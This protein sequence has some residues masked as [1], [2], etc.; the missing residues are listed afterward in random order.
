MIAIPSYSKGRPSTAT[1]DE[2]TFHIIFV[3]MKM[4][5]A[6]VRIE[7]MHVYVCTEWLVSFS[8]FLLASVLIESPIWVL[9]SKISPD[10]LSL[11]LSPLFLS[12]LVGSLP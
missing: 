9:Y 4:K 6:T 7:N 12:S 5:L 11:K 3:Y 8:L 2:I 1:S 10:I